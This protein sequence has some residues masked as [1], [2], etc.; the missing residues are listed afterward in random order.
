MS[1]QQMRK[2]EASSFQIAVSDLAKLEDKFL[3]LAQEATSGVTFR[4]EMLYASTAIM[5]N[6]YLASCAV[7]NPLYLRSAFQQVAA[8]GLTLNPAKGLSYLVPREGKVIL[9]ISYRGMIRMAVLDGAIKDCIVE[10]VY[11][12]DQF[13]YQGKRK[14]P[15][16]TFDPFSSEEERGEFIGVYVEALLPDGR[17]YVEAIPAREIY[18]ARA[19]SELWKKKKIGPWV[20]FF[21]AMAK[22]AAIKSARKYWP[23]GSGKLDEAIAYLNEVGGEGFSSQ[24]VPL[25][26]VERHMGMVET[27]EAEPEALEG[28]VVGEQQAEAT[29]PVSAPLQEPV[30][31][32]QNVQQEPHTPTVQVGDV[33]GDMPP[34]RLRKV[35][36]V[37]KRA[38]AGG[39]WEAAGNYLAELGWPEEWRSYAINRLKAAQYAAATEGA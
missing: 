14:S 4:Q 18:M 38:E 35:E 20:D 26:V 37:L 28:L 39:A 12:K 24:D 34:G 29:Q 27:I 25:E 7:R 33:P 17:L 10:L 8:C 11:S 3:E 36:A 13:V 6:E 16:H 1:V 2:P 15:D 22:K 31:V 19:A 9:D 21:V 23:Q 5:N 30:E 32:A